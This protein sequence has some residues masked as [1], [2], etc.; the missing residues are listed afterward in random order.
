MPSSSDY[1]KKAR[2]KFSTTVGAGGISA[3]GSTL[4]LTDGTGIDTD[5]GVILVIDAVSPAT[6]L[7]TPLLEE[8]I[9]G[10]Y[11]AGSVSGCTRGLEGTTAQA[12]AAGAIVTMYF[13]ESHWDAV[14]NGILINHNQ[15]GTQKPFTEA[16]IV[17]STQISANAVT[18]TKILDGAVTDVKSSLSV[19]GSTAIAGYFY[20]GGDTV[21]AGG[22]WALAILDATGFNSGGFVLTGGGVKV[23][24]AGKYLFN[25]TVSVT[26]ATTAASA[27]FLAAYNLNNSTAPTGPWTREVRNGNNPQ[28]VTLTHVV[29]IAADD[30]LYFFHFWGTAA[31]NYRFAGAGVGDSSHLSINY[32]GK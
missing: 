21:L 5:T 25:W 11:S 28:S 3:G 31:Y 27:E 8:V 15:D 2:R 17:G 30:I 10:V 20:P 29:D 7:A 18:T 12:H 23:P 16:N 24:K 1:F 9:S 6:G 26:D 4:P 22:A 19:A 14:M 32:V 13:T